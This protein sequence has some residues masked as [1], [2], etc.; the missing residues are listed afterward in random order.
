MS[1]LLDDG[2]DGLLRLR[3][4]GANTISE[5]QSTCVV[6]GMPARAEEIGAASEVLRLP[7]IGPRI[8]ELVAQAIESKQRRKMRELCESLK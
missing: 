3:T 6:Y 1:Y 8:A 2:A 5:H 4:A 7:E